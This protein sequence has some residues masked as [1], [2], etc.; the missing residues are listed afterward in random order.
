[1]RSQRYNRR[2]PPL[3]MLNLAALLQND[4]HSAVLHDARAEG[5]SPN[6]IGRL[7]AAADRVIVNTSPLDRW[8]C[9]NLEL[10]PLVEW[11]RSVPRD[12]LILCGV[13]GT[14]FPSRMME[15]TGARIIMAGEPEISG[16][17][18]FRAL[19]RNS[20]L[21]E[22]PGIHWTEEGEIHWGPPS[23]FADLSALP[24]PAYALVRPQMYE[25]ELLGKKLALIETSRGCPNRCTFCLRTMYGSRVRL[26]D[27]RQVASELELVLSLGDE[28]VYFTD[29]EFTSMRERSLELS[30]IFGRY[31]FRW[32]CQTRV[33]AVDAHLLRQMRKS[34]CS[35][36]HYGIESGVERTRE[37]IGKRFSNTQIERAILETRKAGIAAA[38]FFLFGFPWETPS[39]WKETGRF[40]CS[41]PLSYASFHR[42]TPYPETVLGKAFPLEPWWVAGR[43]EAGQ[44]PDLT[45]IFLKFC[46][47]PAYLRDVFGAGANLAGAF[48]L[49]SSFL[50]GMLTGHASFHAVGHRRIEIDKKCL[51]PEKGGFQ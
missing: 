44:G 13:H 32:C 33:D 43:A 14:L 38:G 18:L 4:G 29:L 42:V 16:P 31:G 15:L 41:L 27:P 46:L 12:K 22:V 19:E 51:P 28:T 3:D 47:R 23:Y 17:A 50:S 24:L 26:K 5:L 40:A 36:I 10:G 21:S 34:G 45:R 37:L 7:A 11:T 1:M 8:Q 39:D 30:E 2:W 35:L 25:Y 48:R 49:F 9:P 20:S 6:S